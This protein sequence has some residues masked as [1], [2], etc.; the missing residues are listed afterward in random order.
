MA[1]KTAD[2]PQVRRKVDVQYPVDQVRD[3]DPLYET[4]SIFGTLKLHDNE[5]LA[6]LFGDTLPSDADFMA[7]E[8][9]AVDNLAHAVPGGGDDIDNMSLADRVKVMLRWP[10]IKNPLIAAWDNLQVNARAE[11]TKN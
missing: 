6:K 1:A 3:D 8:I 4:R 9:L 2:T 7:N 5:S 11:A 10:H